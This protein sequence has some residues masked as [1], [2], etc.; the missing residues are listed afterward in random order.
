MAT[1]PLG[2]PYE[3]LRSTALFGTSDN[4]TGQSPPPGII[5]N[6]KT[7]RNIIDY[8]DLRVRFKFPVM[9]TRYPNAW[10]PF[11][12]SSSFSACSWQK[13]SFPQQPF[14]CEYGVALFSPRPESTW[15]AGP[16]LPP[17]Q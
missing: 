11:P 12:G 6:I 13:F 8:A 17:R 7:R 14:H 3:S 5:D 10:S 9:F 4:L 15:S 1:A 2:R 16:V